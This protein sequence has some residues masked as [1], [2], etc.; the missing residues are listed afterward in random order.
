MKALNNKYLIRSFLPWLLLL[1]NPHRTIQVFHLY[2]VAQL[3]IL[4]QQIVV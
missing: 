4:S 2:S 3:G 1:L